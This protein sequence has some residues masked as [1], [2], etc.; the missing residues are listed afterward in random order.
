MWGFCKG[1]VLG[2][3]DMGEYWWIGIGLFFCFFRGFLLIKVI[4]FFEL[5]FEIDLYGLF[6]VFLSKGFLCI[7]IL[8][9]GFMFDVILLFS[10]FVLFWE[11]WR[12]KIGLF[13]FFFRGVLFLFILKIMRRELNSVDVYFFF[14]FL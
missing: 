3:V 7:V 13:I 2:G 1:G 9:D 10:L 8:F 4:F 6:L 5:F 11:E 12:D 14:I